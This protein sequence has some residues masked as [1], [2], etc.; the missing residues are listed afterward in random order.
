MEEFTVEVTVVTSPGLYM[1]EPFKVESFDVD[2]AG[3][4]W[5][6]NEQG[7]RFVV[8]APGSWVRATRMD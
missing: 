3:S 8:F 2:N 7:K 1:N 5:L 6:F 4:L